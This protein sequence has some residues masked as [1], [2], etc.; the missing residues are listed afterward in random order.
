MVY[1]QK[2]YGARGCNR[3]IC[4][5]EIRFDYDGNLKRNDHG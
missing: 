1:H 5:D 3:I 2:K 4:I